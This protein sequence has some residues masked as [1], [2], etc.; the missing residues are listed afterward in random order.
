MVGTPYGSWMSFLLNCSQNENQIRK[1]LKYAIVAYLKV[2][3][4]Q[5]HERPEGEKKVTSLENDGLLAQI[6]T[7]YTFNTNGL[8][9]NIQCKLLTC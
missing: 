2:V 6:I 5:L 8:C 9:H 1:N 7:R 4:K 3:F